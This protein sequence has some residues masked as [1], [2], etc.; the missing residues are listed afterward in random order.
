M[1]NL[2]KWTAGNAADY[3]I[4]LSVVVCLAIVALGAHL[5]SFELAPEPV[6]YDGFFYEWQ[7]A[8]PTVAG[9]VTAWLGFALHNLLVWG[10]IYYAQKHYKTYTDG[11]RPANWAALAI[12]T[13]FIGLH[14]GQTAVF[15]DAKAQ[16][17]PSWTSQFTVIMMLFVILAME[18]RRRGIFFGK[19]INFRK[20]FYEWLKQYHGYAFSFAVIYTF[21][22]HPMIPTWGHL[23]GF[24]HVILVMV[25]GSLFFTKVHL[26]KRWKLLLEIMVLPHAALVAFNQGNSLLYMFMFGFLF[27]FIVTQ[28]HGIGLKPWLKWLFGAGFLLSIVI[29]Y[30]IQREPRMI[31]EV[32]RIPAILY[33]FAFLTYG[34]WWVLAKISAGRGGIDKQ[35]T[36]PEALPTH[37]PRETVAVTGR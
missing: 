37:T 23:F 24:V 1:F 5:A 15:Y 19:K 7:L 32:I 6:P 21:W 10:T 27:M 28:M 18:N 26:N 8:Q 34:F 35:G 25:Q 14:Y 36:P 20:E 13:I 22:F 11:L 12:N 16:D 9:Q 3:G 30:F 29:V 31:N 17:I 2:R 33:P 4:I